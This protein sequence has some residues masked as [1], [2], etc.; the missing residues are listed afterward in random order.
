MDLRTK[1]DQAIQVAKSVRM[2]GSAQERGGKLHFVGV[3]K[4]EDEKNQIWNALKTIP[5]WKSDIIADIDVVHR[6][7]PV[8]TSGASGRTYTV[9]SGDTLSKIATAELKDVNR[10]REIWDLNRERV[11]NEN[12]IYPRLVLL[13]P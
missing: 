7:Q 1:Y 6:A 9:K 13:M 11:A 5:D 3:V 2:D 12:L 10:W 8:G 4:S